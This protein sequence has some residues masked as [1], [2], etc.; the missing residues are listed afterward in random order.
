MMCA[1]PVILANDYRDFLPLH[2]WE[3]MVHNREW[4]IPPQYTHFS[5]N[6]MCLCLLYFGG[7]FFLPPQWVSPSLLHMSQWC[8]LFWWSSLMTA[9]LSFIF[10]LGIHGMQQG[11]SNTSPLVQS[12]LSL[13]G[14]NV[15]IFSPSSHL[16]QWVSLF[17]MPC[18]CRVQYELSLLMTVMFTHPYT[19]G[20]TWNITGSEYHPTSHTFQQRCVCGCYIAVSFF[21]PQAVSPTLPHTPMM[22]AVLVVLTNNYHAFFCLHYGNAYIHGT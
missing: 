12:P 16:S 1:V 17:H 6:V 19:I 8:V 22:R 11:V 4:V 13:N 7:F 20:N 15:W 9:I 14:C 5:N 2:S 21:S 18:V 3:H 10:A